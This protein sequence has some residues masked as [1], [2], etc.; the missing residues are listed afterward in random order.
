MLCPLL[1]PFSAHGEELPLSFALHNLHFEKFGPQGMNIEAVV[2]AVHRDRDGRLWIG[3]EGGLYLYDGHELRVFNQN[4]GER[5]R[6]PDYFVKAIAEADGTIW[7]GTWGGGLA[8]FDE[9]TRSTHVPDVRR[10]EDGS[11]IEFDNKI[12]S[13]AADSQGQL[14]LGTFSSGLFRF[15][16]ATG[17]LR[18]IFR[19]PSQGRQIGNRIDSL[20]IDDKDRVWFAPYR[21]GLHVLD[22]DTGKPV[23]DIDTTHLQQGMNDGIVRDISAFPDGRIV[24]LYESSMKV[25]DDDGAVLADIAIPWKEASQSLL[26]ARP[27]GENSVLVGT[28]KGTLYV[29]SVSGEIVPLPTG[30]HP[31]AMEAGITWDMDLAAN[32]DLLI[33][34]SQGVWIVPAISRQFWTINGIEG[35]EH[36]FFQTTRAIARVDDK[37]YLNDESAIFEIAFD[38]RLAA[39]RILQGRLVGDKPVRTVNWMTLVPDQG[40]LWI[41]TDGG[42]MHMNLDG[43]ITP[44][45]DFSGLLHTLLFDPRTSTL[46]LNTKLGIHVI[47]PA[48]DVLEVSRGSL[49]NTPAHTQTRTANHLSFGRHEDIWAGSFTGLN[50]YDRNTHEQL[51]VFTDAFSD[52]EIWNKPFVTFVHPLADDEALIGTGDGVFRAE[53]DDTGTISGLA[54]LFSETPLAATA[55][56]GVFESKP[57]TLVLFSGHGFVNY[58]LESGT[59]ELITQDDGVPSYQPYMAGFHSWP[60][61]LAILSG[62]SGPLL[63]RPSEIR[64]ATPPQELLIS[65]VLSFRG[66]DTKVWPLADNLEFQYEDKVIRI[67]FGLL[68]Y[69]MPENNR[70]KLRLKGFSDD[71]LDIGRLNEFSFTNLDPGSYQLE[72]RAIDGIVEVPQTATLDF[73]VLPPWWLT[74]WA[75][76]LYA[77]V[78]LGSLAAYLL[79]LQRKL[80]RERDITQRLRE[81]DRIK[82]HFLS[83]LEEKVELA[84]QD[85]RHAVEAM[86]I[87]NIELDAAQQRAVDASRLK[88]EFLANMSHEIRTPM[89]G[90][91]GFTRL[92]TKSTLDH[93]QRD[94]LETIEKSATSLLGIIN[95]VLD[96]SKIEAGKLMIDNTGY[97]LRQCISDTLDALTPIAYEKN[98]ELVGHVDADLPDG[99]RGDPVRLRQMVTNLVGN[100]LKFTDSGH[101]L[102]RVEQHEDRLRI[103]VTDTGRGITAEDRA[104]LFQAFERGNVSLSGR[105]TGTGLGLV[106]TKKLCEAMGGRIELDSVPGQ[107]TRIA[108]E[109]PLV[110]DRNPENRYGYGKPLAGRSV[111]LIDANEHSR[112]AMR[113]RLVHW[114]ANVSSFAELV[115]PPDDNTDIAIIGIPRAQLG[116]TGVLRALC[117][118][119]PAN[120][121]RLCLAASIDHE[122]LRS[123]G[124]ACGAVCIQKVGHREGQLRRILGLLG[125]TSQDLE[126]DAAPAARQSLSTLNIL[127]ADDNRINRYYLKKILELHGAAVT[128]ADSGGAVLQAL[129]ESRDIDIALL[130]IHMPD[131]D[132]LEVA[133]RIRAGG[134]TR[135]PLLAVSANVQPETYE[136]AVA[137]GINDYLLKP[138][139]ETR[140]VE[141]ILEWTGRE[142]TA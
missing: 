17:E 106:I 45:K 98:L 103:S 4:A 23:N 94:Y 7:I 50:R 125:V 119:L 133:R 130:D 28:D 104:R 122:A 58:H 3:T 29:N 69:L 75:Y 5:S 74:W 63:F 51:T 72:V 79:S 134:N 13:M 15:D 27:Y 62:V 22:A 137:A 32:G 86:E 26:E 99:L 77:L 25:L 44:L 131:M 80:A 110:A 109:L 92:L 52:S 111:L 126:I 37:L 84:T 135:L 6:L 93:D 83:E 71:W 102:V 139:E 49:E 136:A 115:M 40:G 142:E 65:D 60:D 112:D 57:G 24:I 70:Y 42:A 127:V 30:A 129:K 73:T 97:D 96:V 105:Y 76:A 47:D 34:G 117:E 35:N 10:A 124:E 8:W 21:N 59:F 54:R 14:W 100:A 31:H 20:F 46:L 67:K 9:A 138:V 120:V 91:L 56:S 18:S 1:L 38:G 95:D 53:L 64:F 82:T 108:I 114:G 132:G 11:D 116:D 19:I 43:E 87:K 107:G 68:D 41:S 88:S 85:L 66:N 78:T 12:W 128:E 90:I 39:P 33:G 48:I 61:G 121:P 140:L 101:V 113:A 123:L 16:P 55:F 118:R 81:A 141:A 36:A 2:H 89:N